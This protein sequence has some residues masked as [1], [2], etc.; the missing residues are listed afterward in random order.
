MATLWN[1]R[2]LRESELETFLDGDPTHAS[3]E[4]K[5]KH[6]RHFPQKHKRHFPQVSLLQRLSLRVLFDFTLAVF[7]LELNF[8]FP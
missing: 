4:W 7:D 3:S 1:V 2:A 6:K 5:Q 8:N